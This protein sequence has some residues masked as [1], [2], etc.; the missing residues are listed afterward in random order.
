MT[1]HSVLTLRFK[2][3]ALH[4]RLRRVSKMIGVS[5]NEL[6]EVAIERELDLLAADLEQELMETVKTLRSWQYDEGELERDAA[7]FAAGE[8][9]ERDPVRSKNVVDPAGIGELF[10]GPMGR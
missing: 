10:A 3:S 7:A 4:G 9:F 8:A 2:R 1:K 6:A 5:M